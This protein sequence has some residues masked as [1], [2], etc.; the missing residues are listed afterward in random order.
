MTVR[1]LLEGRP[2][3]GKT[4]VARRLVALLRDAGHRVAGFTTEELREG[5]RRVGFAVESA[6]GT[7]A[8]LA[9]VRLAGPP[10]VGRYGVDL[11][12]FEHVAL[13]ALGAAQGAAAVVVDELGKMELASGRFCDAVTRILEGNVPVVATVHAFR[14]PF[15]DALKHRPDV[16]RIAVTARTRDGL[17][18]ELF[19]RLVASGP[20]GGAAARHGH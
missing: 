18:Q 17:P 13:P 4:T 11:E 5:D 8:T 15:T 1:I 10:R 20:S 6:S 3:V 9:H 7:R 19:H 14:H 12:G 16:E 2:G